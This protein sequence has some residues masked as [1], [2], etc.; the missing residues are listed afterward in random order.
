MAKYD[1]PRQSGIG[2]LFDSL[3]LMALVLLALFVPFWMKLAGSGKAD[4]DIKDKT[5]W[6]GLGQN[7]TMAKAWEA[8][9]QTPE[10]ASAMIA[11]RFDYV[12][13]PV[14]LAATAALIIGYFFV[15]FKFSKTEYKDVIDERFGKK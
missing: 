1:P 7:E 4:I 10:T 9:G 13:D 12:V 11:S 3:F 5:T 14:S 2:Q 8:V 6:A 15:V